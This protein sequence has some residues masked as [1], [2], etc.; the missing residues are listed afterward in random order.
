VPKGDEGS[1]FKH[2][3]AAVLGILPVFSSHLAAQELQPRAYIPAPVGLNFV[4]LG[5]ARNGGSV[6]FDSSIPIDNAQGTSNVVTAGFGQS[7]GVLGRSAQILGILS[8]VQG[9]LSGLYLGAADDRR[10]SGLS[11]AVFRYSMNIHG[12]PAMTRP[13]F[14]GYRQKTIVG[15]SIT[16]SPPTGQYDPNRLIN[17]GTN[18][19]A[20]KPELGV[21]RA[22]GKWTLEG[23]FGVWL[24]SAND[25]FDGQSKNTRAPLGSTQAHVVRF[26]PHRIWLAFDGTYYNGGRTQIDG[27][28]QPN[29]M[30]NLRLGGTFG[31]SLKPR[32]ALKIGYFGGAMARYG[33]NNHSLGITYTV[34]WQKGR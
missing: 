14:A 11:D 30:G 4:T 2:A 15:A 24:Y 10:R 23:A 26:L 12:A 19:W 25:R 13:R 18:R 5:Y 34:I 33:Q 3:A 22:I 1:I 31:I 16:V 9:D 20:V 32:H 6:L 27:V 17:I 21:S 29:Y 28:D 8:Y 7:I